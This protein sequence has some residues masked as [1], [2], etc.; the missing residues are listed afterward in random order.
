MT[1]SSCCEAEEQRERAIAVATDAGSP[2][3]VAEL[4][5]CPGLPQTPI[6]DCAS[7]NATAAAISADMLNSRRTAQHGT[8]QV[9]SDTS[10]RRRP[11]F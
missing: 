11:D 1:E 4:F 8:W 10:G 9:E 5:A 3:S 6:P 7:E 2:E